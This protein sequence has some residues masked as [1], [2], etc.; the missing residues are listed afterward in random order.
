MPPSSPRPGARG[1]A[2]RRR[3][4]EM[5]EHDPQPGHGRG[6]AGDVGEL[7]VPDARIEGP[8]ACRDRRGA[9]EE[10]L[11]PAVPS[12]SLC[13]QCRT[14]TTIGSSSRARERA[15]RVDA[16]IEP[17]AR[18][19]R[20]HAGLRRRLAPSAPRPGT[21]LR[22]IGLHEHGRAS[23]LL[24]AGASSVRRTA[25]RTAPRAMR[26][27]AGTDPTGAD[28][29]R[30]RACRHP[31][32]CVLVVC[33]HPINREDDAMAVTDEAIEKI[34]AMI[35]SGELCPAIG[36]LP[37]RS[38]PSGSG[39]PAIRCA[40][41]SRHSRSSGCSTC[42]GAT[43][44]MSRV[45]S[46]ICCSRR[47]LRVDMH[48]DDSMLEIF[49]VRR[50]LESQATGLAATLGTDEAIAE[51]VAEVDGVDASVTIEEL[52]GARH[53]LPPRHRPHGG[54][55][56]PREPD[57]AP[58]QSDRA[59]ARLA[60][61]HRGRRRGAH[62][63]G[64]RAI[65]EAIARHDSALATSLSTAHIAGVER[66]LRPAAWGGTRDT[67]WRRPRPRSARAPDPGRAG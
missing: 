23:V 60:R 19:D 51:L 7:P 12:G 66:W 14:P 63:V 30:E 24:P 46:R 62:P 9:G 37:R 41:P 67:A 10:R 25:R 54:E 22:R 65:A 17:G 20:D 47:S 32:T 50:M 5:I 40:R 15:R 39:S 29:N 55:R 4:A 1:P 64:A 48:D 11:E 27:R 52:V 34:K 21:G 59:G 36:S 38:W 53:P 42:G 35:V 18:D 33:R 13:R 28:V 56:L 57:R 44:P 26:S 49:A 43:V 45:W 2:C 6:E 58:Q 61:S 16:A 8:P 3:L 31:P